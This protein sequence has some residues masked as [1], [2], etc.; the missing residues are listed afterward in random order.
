[1]PIQN[2]LLAIKEDIQNF[3]KTDSRFSFQG[4]QYL[5][6]I[7]DGSDRADQGIN[8]Y[9]L[10]YDFDQ[11]QRA[12]RITVLIEYYEKENTTTNHAH[13]PDKI[14]ERAKIFYNWFIKEYPRTWGQIAADKKLIVSISP[15]GKLEFFVSETSRIYGD[16]RVEVLKRNDYKFNVDH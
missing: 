4:T 14:K 7:E 12:E 11:Q 5:V 9:E 10:D 13:N 3:L 8:L 2:Y 1:M 6:L 15:V 16:F